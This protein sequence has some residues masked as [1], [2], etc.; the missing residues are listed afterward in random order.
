M[1]RITYNDRDRIIK[2]YSQGV[3]PK[4]LIK[5]YHIPSST[6]YY[7][8][9][10]IPIKVA[11]N[12]N[13]VH[14][15]SSWSRLNS[16]CKKIESEL[17]FVQRAIID[18]MEPKERMSIIDEKFGEESL[19][20]Q[21]DALQ[22]NRGT[23]LNHRLRGKKENSIYKQRDAK[24][25]AMIKQIF[26]ESGGV[27]GPKKITAILRKRNELVSSDYVKKL[28]A[29]LG[30]ISSLSPKDKEYR[31]TTSY[32]R[33]ER[34]FCDASEVTD[35]NQVWVSDTTAVQI[36]DVYYF[37]CV[38]IDLCSRRVLAWKIGRNN[39]TQLTKTTFLEAYKN[40]NPKPKALVIH[41]DNGACYTSF[42]F[43]KALRDKKI[44]H[45]YSRPKTPHDNAVAEAFFKTLKREGICMATLPRLIPLRRM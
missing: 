21:C 31:Y 3:K 19:N 33:R 22:V 40:R 4:A 6:L 32:M 43:N 30:F 26:E 2:L 23:Y 5:E 29:E 36:K 9:N 7:W 28:M 15:I 8:I 12:S 37:I 44:T 10:N 25:T 17:A 24:Y 11:A 39:S 27:Y 41:T 18:K 14:T 38:F 34:R 45:T 20:V 1:K 13:Q 35:I 42:S 16:H